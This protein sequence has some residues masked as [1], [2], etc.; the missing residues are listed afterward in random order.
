MVL[1]S[2]YV[3][4]MFSGQ[5]YAPRFANSAWDFWG[6]T[7]QCRNFL[8]VLFESQRIFWGFDFCPHSII[9]VTWNPE[10]HP[11]PPPPPPGSR[12]GSI[13]FISCMNFYG[14]SWTK[15]GPKE[16]ENIICD[17]PYDFRDKS[18]NTLTTRFRLKTKEIDFNMLTKHTRAHYNEA[19]LLSHITHEKQ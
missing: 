14:S 9:P 1:F 7:F 15:N 17:P 13:S 12:S 2:C 11:P 6:V 19:M 5:F 10:Y 8:W 16:Y 18:D 4:L 3:I